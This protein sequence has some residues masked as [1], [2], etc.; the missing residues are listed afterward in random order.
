MTS[1]SSDSFLNSL[2]GGLFWLVLVLSVVG[3]IQ[4]TY[5][6]WKT[7][8]EI[9]TLH[10]EIG[11][12]FE[13]FDQ[14]LGRSET[15]ILDSQKAMNSLVKSIPLDIKKDLKTFKADIKSFNRFIV[16]HNSSK[17]SGKVSPRPKRKPKKHSPPHKKVSNSSKPSTPEPKT[18]SKT[19][20]WDYSDWRLTGEYSGS[21]GDGVFSYKLHQQFEGVLIEG[22][23]DAGSSSYVRVWELDESGKRISPPLLVKAF[24]SVKKLSL[25]EDFQWL[26]LHLDIGISL[27]LGSEL[28][29]LPTVGLSFSGHGATVNDLNWR[30][31]RFGVEPSSE[32]I[33]V[34]VCPGL[35]NVGKPLPLF[36]NIWIG[37]CY[38][39]DG[40]SKILLQLTG[41][42]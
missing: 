6:L 21:C 13:S 39:Y 38:G 33:G 18:S 24:R 17:R 42:L 26:A 25:S 7:Q 30:L 29:V 10:K 2:K 36:S 11:L 41:V 16:E 12:K 37:P 19:C 3:Y 34:S 14:K 31:F 8:N 22:E 9:T 40:S 20:N 5:R 15:I 4:Q 27:T 32:K 1:H 23:G 28:E 35:Y